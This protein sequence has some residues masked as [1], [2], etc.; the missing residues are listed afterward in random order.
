M[1]LIYETTVKIVN[2]NNNKTTP[3]NVNDFKNDGYIEVI[4]LNE[5]SLGIYKNQHSKG[6]DSHP[7][8]MPSVSIWKPCP[9]LYSAL[10]HMQITAI[11]I[12]N[13]VVYLEMLLSRKYNLSMRNITIKL[14]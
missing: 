9:P 3:V 4:K 1:A 13:G 2:A 14:S 10:N 12:A 8:A 5:L 6:I 11:I 7:A